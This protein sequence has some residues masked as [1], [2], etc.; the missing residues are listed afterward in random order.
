M[1][2]VNKAEM[3]V[4]G[5]TYREY[6]RRNRTLPEEAIEHLLDLYDDEFEEDCADCEQLKC[7]LRE[8]A[9]MAGGY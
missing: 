8:I 5:L 3:L 4:N 9:D 1:E 6:F 7:T 2:S